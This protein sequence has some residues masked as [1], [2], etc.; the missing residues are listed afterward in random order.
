[1]RRPR[2]FDHLCPGVMVM[3]S[4]IFD[5]DHG[6]NF[7][8]TV[9][10]WSKFRPWPRPKSTFSMVKMVNLKTEIKPVL[11]VKFGI[12]F[13]FY[14]FFSVIF[15]F[16]RFFVFFNFSVLWYFFGFSVCNSTKMHADS[17]PLVRPRIAYLPNNTPNANRSLLMPYKSYYTQ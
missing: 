14:W 15:R 16:F 4:K 1:M 7:K 17:R 2:F 8:I 3:W 12:V 10:K 11:N 6:Q 9:V 5:L 13:G